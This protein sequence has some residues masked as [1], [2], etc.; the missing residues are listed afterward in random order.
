MLAGGGSVPADRV[1]DGMDMRGFLLG[2]AE[3]SGRDTVLCFNGNRLQAVKWR[4]WK[5]HLFKQ[6]D[7]YSTWSPYNAPHVHNLEWD[8][9]EGY[10]HPGA[11][12]LEEYDAEAGSLVGPIRRISRGS[13]DMKWWVDFAHYINK[14]GLY[15]RSAA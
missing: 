13:T 8:P 4:Q 2:D 14:H 11:I 15:Q 12:V 10:E 7:F 5:A 3:E 1:I 6:D 9:R